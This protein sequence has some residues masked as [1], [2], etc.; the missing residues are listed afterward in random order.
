MSESGSTTKKTAA[1]HMFFSRSVRAALASQG[2]RSE[3]HCLSKTTKI[4]AMRR[5]FESTRPYRISSKT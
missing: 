5:I 3:T 1:A 2:F 4:T